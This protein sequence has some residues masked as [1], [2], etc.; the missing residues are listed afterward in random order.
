MDIKY[1]G[2]SY[3]INRFPTSSNK[4]LRPWN[5]ADEFTLQYI[6]E[7]SIN[8]KNIYL[9]NDRFGFFANVLHSLNPI[10]VVDYKSQERAIIRNQK[11]NNLE[12]DFNKFLTPLQPAKNK[13]DLAIVRI[14]K[15]TDLFELHLQNIAT[16][17]SDNGIVI[18]P[19]MTKYFNKSMVEVAEKYFSSIEQ[20]LAVKKGRLIILKSP[21]KDIKIINRNEINFNNYNFKQYY[22]VFSSNHIDYA[23]QF[24]LENFEFNKKAE[25]ALD[26]ASGN[27]IIAHH[28]RYNC[29]AE[30]HLVD[31]MNLAIE[32]SKLNIADNNTYFH[33]NYTLEEFESGFFDLIVTNPPFHF[34]HENN[35]EVSLELFKQAKRCLKKD[36]EFWVVANQHLNYK[37][38]LA[39]LFSEV[40]IINDNEKFIIYKCVI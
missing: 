5:S 8:T 9:Y 16:N 20:S 27:G 24:L 1:K 19:F 13:I 35:I 22:G 38:H 37:V 10:S 40:T 11:L 36:G 32:S 17:L 4:S 12:Y 23:T 14:P 33:W 3:T 25:M 28:L 29:N 7:N 21:K 31:D 34:E 30:I 39:K 6:D 18:C 2:R 26:L 15:S